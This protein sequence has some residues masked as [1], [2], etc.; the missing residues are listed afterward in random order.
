MVGGASGS[1]AAGGE[2]PVAGTSGVGA[3]GAGTGGV[4]GAAGVAGTAMTGGSGGE[5]TGTPAVRIVGRTVSNGA[6]QRFAWPGVHFRARFTG[7][8]ASI[9]LNDGGN[10]NRFTVVVDGGTPTT[11]TTAS[12]QSSYSLATGLGAGTHEVLVWRNTESYG[13]ITEFSGISDFGTGGALLSP[14]AAPDRRLE[15]IGD[16][17]SCG[18]GV[19]GTNTSCTT[20]SFTN[21]YLAYGAVAA[22]ALGADLHTVAYSGI[23]MSRSYRNGSEPPPP[24]MADRYEDAITNDDTPWDFSRFTPHVVVINLGTNDYSAGDPGQ[25]YV[26]RYTS[27]LTTVRSKYANAYII[28]AIQVSS[29]ATAING[30]VNARKTGGDT[31]IEAF[32]LGASS[33]GNACASHPDTNGQ[34][35]MGDALAARIRTV[36]GW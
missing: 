15:I 17:I 28:C 30:V 21:N 36:M 13:G 6:N 31:A 3:G 32:D 8:Q 27:F 14:P 5:P 10:R 18:A 22:R 33:N 7:T 19:E 11:F 2:A 25:D 4:G 34:R 26:T 29:S 16:S 1:A 24:V 35:A 12:G 23:G 20:D 9:Q